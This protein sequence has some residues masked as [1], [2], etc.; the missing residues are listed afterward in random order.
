MILLSPIPTKIPTTL[1]FDPQSPLRHLV[2]E[3]QVRQHKISTNIYKYIY[4][5]A[6]IISANRY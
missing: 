6:Y 3:D 2:R 4:N 5:I 1:A